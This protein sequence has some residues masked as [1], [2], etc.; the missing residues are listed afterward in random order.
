MDELRSE[1][2]FPFGIR[3]PPALH[4]DIGP[5]FRQCK[6]FPSDSFFRVVLQRDTKMILAI[7]SIAFAPKY[8]SLLLVPLE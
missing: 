7:K 3:I 5:V 4:K 8:F 6:L 2:S 1:Q